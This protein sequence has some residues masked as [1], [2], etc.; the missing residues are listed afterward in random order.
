MVKKESSEGARRR[1]LKVEKEIQFQ[2][3][4]FLYSTFKGDLPGIVSI[5]KVS[6]TADLRNARVFFS[7]L[8]GT[9]QDEELAQ[10]LLQE[11]APD[12]Q[13]YLAKNMPLRYTPKLTFMRDTSMEKAIKIEQMIRDL[14]NADRK[15]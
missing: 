14:G 3:S 4:K 8:N 2:V 9:D 10:E 12:M 7:V 11:R 6:A 5:V 1:V 13:S 15:P